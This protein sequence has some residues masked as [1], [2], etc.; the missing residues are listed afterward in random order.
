MRKACLVALVVRLGPC[1]DIRDGSVYVARF[2]ARLLK[3]DVPTK[4]GL[5]EEHAHRDALLSAGIHSSAHWDS[6]CSAGSFSWGSLAAIS[7]GQAYIFGSGTCPT[8]CQRQQ[9]AKYQHLESC[10]CS[11]PNRC[12]IHHT[13]LFWAVQPD[14]V[15]EQH[16]SSSQYYFH[17][18][19]D[20]ENILWQCERASS[21]RI[22]TWPCTW[23]CHA[24]NGSWQRTHTY[25][26][27]PNIKFRAQAAADSHS[28]SLH[29]HSRDLQHYCNYIDQERPQK[30]NE[31][32]Q[33]HLGDRTISKH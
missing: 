29:L 9:Y 28:A 22:C 19:P 8:D 32:S 6:F 11:L 24:R 23:R 18:G 20:P 26:H 12:P 21:Q 3:R 31:H 4:A 33:C 14:T 25:G 15:R 30:F 7:S 2:T 5:R 13:E 16:C 1:L 17:P 27:V 10:L